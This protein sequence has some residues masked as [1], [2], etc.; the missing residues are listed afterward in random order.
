[1]EAEKLQTERILEWIFDRAFIRN[2][3]ESAK[4]EMFYKKKAGRAEHYMHLLEPV[5]R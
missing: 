5:E 2:C 3:A 1:M 4:I